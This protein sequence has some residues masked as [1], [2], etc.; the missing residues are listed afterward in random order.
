VASSTIQKCWKCIGFSP[1]SFGTQ[2]DSQT[3]QSGQQLDESESPQTIGE[4][5]QAAQIVDAHVTADDVS[6]WL[7]ID[8]HQ[9]D[10]ENYKSFSRSLMAVRMSPEIMNAE[11]DNEEDSPPCRNRKAV[12]MADTLLRWAEC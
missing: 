6:D 1:D 8:A 12:D 2:E 9:D 10:Y 11:S 3:T 4:I 5:L 7:S